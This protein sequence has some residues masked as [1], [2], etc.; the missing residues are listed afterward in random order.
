M[1]DGF[2]GMEMNVRTPAPSPPHPGAIVPHRQPAN[3]QGGAVQTK[4]EADD[5]VFDNERTNPI[6]A[7]DFAGPDEDP[8][9]TK[10]LPSSASQ[11]SR[12]P[13]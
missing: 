7:D 6:R 12:A 3:E 11:N 4:V 8:E 9:R 13:P 5:V 2:D 1:A 10:S